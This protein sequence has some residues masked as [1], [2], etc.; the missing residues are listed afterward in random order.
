MQKLL[1]ATTN[2]GKLDEIK[3]ILSDL[4][5]EIV[6]LADVGII[7][8][9]IE[10]GNTYEENAQ[11]KAIFYAKKSNIPSVADDGGIEISALENAPGIHSKRWLGDNTT[12][13]DL[14]THMKKVSRELPDKNRNARFVAVLSFAMPDGRVWSV[15]GEVKGIIAKEPLMNKHKG[16]PFRAYFYLPE[17][18]KYYQE[19][20]LT[21]EDKKHYNHRYKA[22][23]KLEVVI[24]KILGV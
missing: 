20:Q 8:D 6:S 22:L 14:L 18:Q 23:Q 1:I 5:L 16:F 24:K 15:E 2:P 21:K 3:R 19:E 11:K 13:E 10:D 12:E 4:P 17:I 7:D 9:V